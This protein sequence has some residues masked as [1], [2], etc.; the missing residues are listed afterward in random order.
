MMMQQP[1]S[2]TWSCE[3]HAREEASVS[4]AS[5]LIVQVMLAEALQWLYRGIKEAL[6]ALQSAP[7]RP[8]APPLTQARKRSCLR[9][10]RPHGLVGSGERR[11]DEWRRSRVGWV[12]DM[13]RERHRAPSYA[14]D[15]SGGSSPARSGKR[16]AR[17]VLLSWKEN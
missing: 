10:A 2:I 13:W 16:H 8:H 9:R 11:A 1:I 7:A 15:S 6:Y 3:H 17:H 5:F 4:L 14:A 12:E